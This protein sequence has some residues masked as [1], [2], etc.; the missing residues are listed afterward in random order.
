MAEQAPK[1]W[2]KRPLPVDPGTTLPDDTAA[3]PGPEADARGEALASEQTG[4]Y[5]MK[6]ELARGGQAGVF[7]AHDRQMGRDGAFKQPLPGRPQDAQDRFL[8][9]A[10]R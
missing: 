4:H 9:A 3:A 5:V 7:V 6:G 1:R 8:R 10:R 2:G